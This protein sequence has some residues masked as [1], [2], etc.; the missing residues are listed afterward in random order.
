MKIFRRAL[1]I[2]PALTWPAIALAQQAAAPTP[3]AA[4]KVEDTQG[5]EDIVVTAQRRAERLQDV[6]VS[7]TAF[8]TAELEKR[9]ITDVQALT[10]NAPAI[11]FS[12]T[13]YGTNDLILAIRGVAPGGVLPNVDQAVGTYVDGI[14][15]ARPE[16][17][18]FALVDI[19]SAEVLRGPQGT[20]FGRN[21]IGGALNVTTNKASYE[22]GGSLKFAYG[23][24]NALTA[25]AVIN[26]PLVDDK[27]AARAVLAHVQHDGWGKS[28]Q[29]GDVANQNDNFVRGSLRAD[30]SDAVRIDLI[31]DY[32]SGRNRQSLWVLRDYLAGT[33]PAAYAPY[34]APEGSRV[35]QQGI[36][37]LNK[38][39]IYTLTGIATAD[40]G[41]AELK[42]ITGYRNMN[43]QGA[44]DQDG[45]PLPTVDVLEF[46][47][48]GDQ[49]S[50]EFQLTGTSDDSRLIWVAGA[51]YF[52]EEVR[53]T[54]LVRA[55]SSLQVNELTP[56]NKSMSA[57]AQ[58][59]YEALPDL[60]ITG[61]I[62]YVVD[63]RDIKYRR[64]IFPIAAAFAG[65]V[66]AN[67]PDGAIGAQTCPY[68]ALGLTADAAACSFSPK[69]ITFKTV[70]FTVGIDYKPDTDSLLYAK[71]ARGYR[72]GGH[73]QPTGTTVTF[74]TPFKEEKV[75]SYEVG[76][77]LSLFDRKLQFSTAAYY[78]IYDNVQQNSLLSSTPT[79]VIAVVN[80]GKERI[81]GAEFEATALLG[82]LRLA[83][84]VGLIE[85]K[86][87]AGPYKDTSVPAV[88]KVTWA[89]SGDFPIEMAGGGRIDLHAD[90]NWRSKVNFLNVG[91]VGAAGLVPYSAFQEAAVTQKGYGLLAARISYTLPRSELTLSV[92]GKNLTNVYYAGRTGSLAAANFNSIVVG[93]P[94]TYG[95]SLSANF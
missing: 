19:A 17:S 64:P 26:L 82:D 74:F 54:G 73:Q 75:D 45:T 67:L 1:M 23:N 61:G 11:T 36:N 28:A 24:Y 72:A 93:E 80:A 44:G 48:V 52:R 51:Y 42:S 2:G 7:V 16:G 87:T 31:G 85:P 56:Q 43:F 60:R 35:S 76:A 53:N 46:E 78:S 13:P 92:F 55:G 89:V 81:Y 27:L 77:K 50:Q 5:L 9:Q 88:S 94:R 47:F 57:F 83:G 69:R 4:A 70:P 79:I 58:L 22:R 25:Q 33:S 20:L 86:F 29:F 3:P 10:Q 62:R 8:G 14:Y 84:S 90:Y 71:F 30:L 95:L 39:Q 38:T 15:Y 6:P 34:V 18:N 68:A 65:V 59:T 66:T 91:S 40:L 49:F 41:F 37:P 63:D 32:Y 21:T 12:A